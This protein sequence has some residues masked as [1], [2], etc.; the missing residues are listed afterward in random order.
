MNARWKRILT[1]AACLAA[2]AAVYLAIGCP[3]RYLTGVSCPSCGMVRACLALL[4]ADPG[5]AA[6]MHPL[7][8]CLPVAA[9][10]LLLTRKNRTAFRAAA[11]VVCV[12]FVAVWLARMISG[13]E[14]VYFRPR[15]GAIYQAFGFL[16]RLLF[17][18]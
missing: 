9:V 13:S 16:F 18:T 3:V 11:A 7:V 4:R 5:Q 15:E 1:A 12:C 2:I 14:V 10:V 8:F 6:R 17:R